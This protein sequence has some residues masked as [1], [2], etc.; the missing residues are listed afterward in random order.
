MLALFKTATNELKNKIGLIKK[1][2]KKE[3]MK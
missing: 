3:R 2:M 1:K